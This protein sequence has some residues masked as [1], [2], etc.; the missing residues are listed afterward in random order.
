MCSKGTKTKVREN[1]DSDC[2]IKGLNHMRYNFTLIR[3]VVLNKTAS[4]TGTVIYS[5]RESEMVQPP[6]KVWP[7]LRKAKQLT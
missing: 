7:S 5:C 4:T 2:I 1:G 6:P 3:K